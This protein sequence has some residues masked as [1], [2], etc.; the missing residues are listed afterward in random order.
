ME[1]IGETLNLFKY[2]M[3]GYEAKKNHSN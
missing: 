3:S 1:L 2:F